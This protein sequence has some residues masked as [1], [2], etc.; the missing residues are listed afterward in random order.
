MQLGLV[1]S[2]L[3]N[4]RLVTREVPSHCSDRVTLPGSVMLTARCKASKV[5]EMA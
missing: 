3:D 2:G 1:P 4:F 5:V